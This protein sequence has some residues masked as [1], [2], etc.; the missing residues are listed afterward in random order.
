MAG[1]ES[2]P[3]ARETSPNGHEIQNWKHRRKEG[4]TEKLTVGKREDEGGSGTVISERQI[5][6]FPWCGGCFFCELGEC[7]KKER[8]ELQGER[9]V[10][11]GPRRWPEGDAVATVTM[12]GVQQHSE[13]AATAL[14]T[15]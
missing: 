9:G 1:G 8:G 13:L 6:E 15:I 10:K 2:F 12:D 11:A 4:S 7:E 3:G 5:P 14:G